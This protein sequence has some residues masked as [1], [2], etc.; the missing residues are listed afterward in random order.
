MELAVGNHGDRMEISELSGSMGNSLCPKCCFFQQ[1]MEQIL[2]R[3]Y[4]PM[5]LSEIW[6]N[7]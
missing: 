1:A 4:G 2:R 6:S 5:A 3:T 7:P